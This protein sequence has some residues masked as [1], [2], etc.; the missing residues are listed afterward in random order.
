MP[1]GDERPNP[2]RQG[3]ERC[4]VVRRVAEAQVAERR[5]AVD[6]VHDRRAAGLGA[7][8]GLVAKVERPVEFGVER[9]EQPCEERVVARLLDDDPHRAEPVAERTHALGEGGDAVRV[10]HLDGEAEAG[11]SRLRPAAELLFRRQPVAGRVQLDRVEPLRVRSQEVARGRPGRVEARLPGRVGEAGGSDVEP[12]W[13]SGLDVHREDRC[14]PPIRESADASPR[15]PLH[16]R[17]IGPSLMC[18]R[19]SSACAG[20]RFVVTGRVPAQRAG[21]RRR[22]VE[23]AAALGEA[24]RVERGHARAQDS[25]WPLRAEMEHGA[26]GLRLSGP[27]TPTSART[28]RDAADAEYARGR[29][30][31]AVR[32][33][34]ST[35]STRTTRGGSCSARPRRRFRHMPPL[36]SASR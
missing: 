36:H 10:G 6:G 17:G 29:V 23:A 33:R 26:P 18:G 19:S 14:P 22:C 11:R 32:R 27:A 31:D 9:V 5:V 30:G 20:R 4:L 1:R 8:P 12:R 15:A 21:V 2:P 34:R 3:C 16:C 13:A 7:G 24:F 25:A 35:S 28:A